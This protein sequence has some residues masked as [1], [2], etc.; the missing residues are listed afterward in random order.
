MITVYNA[1]NVAQQ[2]FL[3]KAYKELEALGKLYDKE[4][5]QGTFLNVEQYFAHMNDLVTLDPVYTMLPSDEQPFVINANARTITV[6][7]D[8]NKCA[9]VV[10]DNM[11]EIVTFTVDRYFDYY[12]LAES[13]IA[14]QWSAPVGEGVSHVGLVDLITE[15][16]KMRFGW[17]LTAEMTEIAGPITFSV[18]FFVEKEIGAEDV[19]TKE[20]KMIYILNTLPATINIRP[21]LN[22]KNP[23][24][25]EEKQDIIDLFAAIAVNNMNPAYEIPEPI[26]FVTPGLN[27]PKQE[28]LGADGSLTLKAQA[29]A[30][31]NGT[32]SYKWYFR[33]G[34][35]PDEKLQK[36]VRATEFEADKAYFI[37][38][39]DGAFVP[40]EATEENFGEQDLY[41]V[42][43]IEKIEISSNND[44]YEVN[45]EVYEKIE[46]RP[47]ERVGS[48]KYYTFNGT[49][50][51]PV[52]G[53][54]NAPEIAD[55]D[56]YE[57]F[58]TLTILNN[59]E[60]K[61]ITGRYWVGA[62]N[63]TGTDEITIEGSTETIEGIN[64]TKEEY[65][66]MCYLPVPKP[67]VFEKNLPTDMFLVDG[68]AELEVVVNE[69][70][71]NPDRTFTWTKQDDDRIPETIQGEENKLTA[72]EAGWYQVNVLSELNRD[73]QEGASKLCRVV[74]NPMAPQVTKL[75]YSI[76]E[77]NAEWNESN[78]NWI[79]IFD[80]TKIGAEDVNF[81]NETGIAI[82]YENGMGEGV[83]NWGQKLRL[84]VSIN[85]ADFASDLKSDKLTYQWFIQEPDKALRPLGPEDISED[86][87]A[88]FVEGKYI[89][90]GEV[91]LDKLALD[92]NVT[93]NGIDKKHIYICQTTNTLVDKTATLT[94][95]NY[96]I[97]FFIW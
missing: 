47:T 75:E 93:Q 51:E 13:H 30:A 34:A 37:Y 82:A 25:E 1:Q 12:D 95:D 59:P 29:V 54:I 73:E 32:I 88:K 78:Q 56:L 38:T 60:V 94:Q 58:T 27:L 70:T 65:S 86:G 80:I 83:A 14:V 49:D 16:G 85:E 23:A 18:R 31:D 28:K 44:V 36:I 46:P 26:Y 50:Y 55:Q 81:N 63:S 79:T 53:D 67:I 8:F 19:G 48:E 39:E 5:G 43:K 76:W 9:A 62:K 42:E 33:E 45:S 6:P 4:L 17:P 89:E 11:C 71:G 64:A 61:N 84:R 15:S 20:T 68:K 2:I 90:S 72:T 35:T 52:I 3:K 74:N 7:A 10:G 40:F 77:N 57:R 21:G 41:Y 97:A 69:D 91:G 96:P 66:A 24:V 22:I 87:N 92:V